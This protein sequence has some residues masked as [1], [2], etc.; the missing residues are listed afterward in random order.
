MTTQET[1][2]EVM[3]KLEEALHLAR[4]QEAA[5]ESEREAHDCGSESD[6]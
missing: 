5:R 3:A 6:A 1:L 4:R 2:K